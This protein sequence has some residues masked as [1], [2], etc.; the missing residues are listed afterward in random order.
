VAIV[1]FTPAAVDTLTVVINRLKRGQS[2]MVGGKDH[3][4]H[5]LVYAGLNDRR[6]WYVFVGIG[7]G[8]A[9]LSILMV[10]LI[11][12]DVVYPILFFLAYFVFV[13]II[14]YRNTIK[15][16]QPKAK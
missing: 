6:V 9:L 3:T 10:Y 13:F 2:P 1:A 11:S 4:T 5:H 7:I 14:L 8:A 15:Y 16:P 12:S